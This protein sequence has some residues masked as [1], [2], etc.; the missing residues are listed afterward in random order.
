MSIDPRLVTP[1]RAGDAI[2][3]AEWNA[4][5][6]A[7]TRNISMSG[8]IQHP[9]GWVGRGARGATEADEVV[10][11]VVASATPWLANKWKYT[12]VEQEMTATGWQNLS[13]GRTFTACLNGYE[14]NNSATGIQGNGV[15]V[16]TLPAGFKL[17][18][19]RGNPVV[20]LWQGTTADNVG[21]RFSEPNGVD[22]TCTAP[23]APQQALGDTDRA[24]MIAMGAA[25]PYLGVT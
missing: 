20:E 22:G 17:V 19:I 15:N 24:Y 11:A 21:W 12:C 13:S 6:A 14:A 8:L 1:K 10:Y 9:A 18:P 25:S 7:A 16:G 2:S 3:A 4:L 23:I 5:A